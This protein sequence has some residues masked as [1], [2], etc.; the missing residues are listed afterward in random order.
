MRPFGKALLSLPVEDALSVDGDGSPPGRIAW[1]D[2]EYEA[3]WFSGCTEVLR[4]EGHE[5]DYR[6]RLCAVYPSVVLAVR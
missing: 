1:R 5:E 2:A 4:R 3:V 6:D